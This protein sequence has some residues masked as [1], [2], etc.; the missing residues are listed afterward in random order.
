MRQIVAMAFVLLIGF[1]SLA[2]EAEPGPAELSPGAVQALLVNKVPPV[3]PPLARQARIQGTVVLKIVINKD[4]DV[5][6]VQLF[7]GHPMLAPAA[8]AAVKQWKYQPY[9]QGGEVV[10]V[11]TTV[12]VNFTL[13]GE[14]VPTG[15]AGD[16]PGGA[17]DTPPGYERVSEA[18]MRTLRIQKIDP[19]YPPLALQAHIQGPVV[20]DLLISAAGEVENVRLVSGH[21]MLAPAS[22]EAAKQ[23]KYMPYVKDGS[24]VAVATRVRLSYTLLENGDGVVGEAA[25]EAMKLTPTGETPPP[26]TLPQHV[27]VSAGVSQGLLVSKVPPEYPPDARDQRVQGTVI[28]SVKIDKEGNVFNVELVSGHPM[29]APAA[30]EAV[31]QWKYRPY[32][33]NGEAV[34]VDT[35]VRVNF[36]LVD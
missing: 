8:I 32:V 18:K 20:L 9:T 25:I 17:I 19:Q 6:D 33:L 28:L 10:E 3:Y 23:W 29:L 36:T 26:L 11:S 21:P 27:R 22:V 7:S 14:P 31:R 2:Q 4:G 12:R 34:E 13:A 1:R 30:I 5:R 16:T 15:M 35:E 24:A